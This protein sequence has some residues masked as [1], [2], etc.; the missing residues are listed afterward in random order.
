MK[1]LVL[2]LVC[3]LVLG[4]VALGVWLQFPRIQRPRLLDESMSAA[5]RRW[6]EAQAMAKDPAQN[7]FLDK[8]F[9][10]YW[11]RQDRE[12]K[13]GSSIAQVVLAWSDF[14]AVVS[15]GKE[16][17]GAATTAPYRKALA[18]F[19]AV[20][21]ELVE[22]MRKPVFLPPDDSPDLNTRLPNFVAVRRCAQAVSAL[23]EARL[24]QGRPAEAAQL[25]CAL[26]SF[27][28]SIK[29]QGSLI[30]TM[31]GA[32]IQNIAAD[33]FLGL[34]GPEARLSAKEWRQ[35]EGRLVESLGLP[36]SDQIADSM[37]TE[38]LAAH[39]SFEAMRSG[40]AKDMAGLSV[41]PIPGWLAREERIVDNVMLPIIDDLRQGNASVPRAVESPTG[42]DYFSGNTGIL[43]NVFI[44]NFVR[45]DGQ[46]DMT[47]QR[48]SALALICE[49][50]AYA[51]SKGQLPRSVEE[52][53]GA[54]LAPDLLKALKREG[55]SY[56]SDGTTATLTLVY[57][58]PDPN[59][60]A[61]VNPFKP[62][63]WVDESKRGGL[64]Y[65]MAAPTH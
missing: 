38:L 13:E 49:I 41:L 33:T 59:W 60:T 64:V 44:P 42:W 5:R 37:Q 45:A 56:V 12:Y 4:A 9:L 11:G 3:L 29:L 58:M 40:K 50:R 15:A 6:D 46:L 19:E 57:R 14:A 25:I 21:P 53:A 31:I 28:D 55:S 23:A 18:D 24:A 62:G 20:A 35:I 61:P 36:A 34:L 27:G 22:Q 26:A 47:R 51:R 63:S 43:A 16:R 10:P 52:L 30:S 17:G 54:G 65:R 48:L 39:N 2:S 7:G 8:T 32:A 1:K